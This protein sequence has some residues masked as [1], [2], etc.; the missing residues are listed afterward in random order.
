[1][2]LAAHINVSTPAQYKQGQSCK[3]DKGHNNF[4]H[5]WSFKK[6]ALARRAWKLPRPLRPGHQLTVNNCDQSLA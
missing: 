1:M 4:P 5:T 3:N 2:L 6:K